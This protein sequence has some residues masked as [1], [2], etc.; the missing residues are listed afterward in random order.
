MIILALFY[1][2]TKNDSLV[3]ALRAFFPRKFLSE[4][5]MTRNGLWYVATSKIKAALG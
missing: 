3:G 5:N 4:L 1:D 2:I